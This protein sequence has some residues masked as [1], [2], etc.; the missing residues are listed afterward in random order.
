[1]GKKLEQARFMATHGQEMTVFMVGMRINKF[2]AVHKWFPVFMAMGPMLRELYTHKELGFL[3]T[4]T[5]MGW[6]T[7]TL[8]QYWNS[9]D[10]LYAYAKG[11]EHMKAWKNFY[12]KA[13]KSEAVGIFHETYAV[14]PGTYE[15]IYNRM[16]A[17]GLSKAI[18]VQPVGKKMETA[19]DRLKAQ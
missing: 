5:L 12:Q 9:K 10:Q 19:S 6:R 17:F 16:P 15:T 7:V 14:A 1:M 18:G 13:A 11:Q 4:E 3:S 2:W 8:I